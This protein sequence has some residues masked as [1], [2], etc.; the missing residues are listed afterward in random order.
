ML[1]LLIYRLNLA[2]T[3]KKVEIFGREC[4]RVRRL[5]AEEGNGLVQN[6]MSAKSRQ[7]F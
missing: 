7:E 3:A 2:L 6:N 5:C 4:I 1:L